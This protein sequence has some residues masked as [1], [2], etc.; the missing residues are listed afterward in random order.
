MSLRD[1]EADSA[2][3]RQVFG[4]IGLER[5]K[6]VHLMRA[7]FENAILWPYENALI[8]MGVPFGVA[9]TLWVRIMFIAAPNLIVL[10][11]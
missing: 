3:A 1:I 4:R 8:G 9:E 7:G 6:P 5:G 2:S 10:Q 11:R